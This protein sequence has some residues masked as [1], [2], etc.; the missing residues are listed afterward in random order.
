MNLE[1][2]LDKLLKEDKIKKQKTDIDYLNGLLNSA[3]QNFLSAEY[4]LRGGFYETAFKTAYDGLLQVSRVVL[5][6]NGYRPNDREQHKTT[7]LVAG[8]LLGE[9]FGE[10][11]EKV[12]KYR[13]KRNRAVYQPL[14]F[15]SKSEAENILKTAKEYW[16]SVSAYLQGKNPQIEL[17]NL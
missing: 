10:L 2:L 12:D 11:I 9:E 8:A 17:F 7:F 15:I 5:L 1:K 13:I 4:N 6:L 14:D 3:C 16:K